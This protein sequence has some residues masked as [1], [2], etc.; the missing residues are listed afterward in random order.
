MHD[1]FVDASKTA[2]PALYGLLDGSDLV[3]DW[4][5]MVVSPTE[6]APLE[7]V[8]DDTTTVADGPIGRSRVHRTAPVPVGIERWPVQVDRPGKLIN[9]ESGPSNRAAE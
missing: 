9:F 1:W 6:V 5:R 4:A 3:I 8:G 7:D 2:K